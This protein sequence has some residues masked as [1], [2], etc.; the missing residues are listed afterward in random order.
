MFERVLMSMCLQSRPGALLLC[1]EAVGGEDAN[2]EPCCVICQRQWRL[3]GVFV[4]A[5]I[6]VTIVVMWPLQP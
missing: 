5:I 1:V 2:S 6:T 3:L 4:A